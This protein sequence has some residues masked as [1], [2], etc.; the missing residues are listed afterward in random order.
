MGMKN[1]GL[2]LMELMIAIVIVGI[3]AAFAIPSY[4]KAVNKAEERQMMTNLRAIVAAQ[5]IYKAQNGNYWPAH[6]LVAPTANQGIAAINAALKLNILTSGTKY[7]YR[8]LS[9]ANQTYQCYANY[10]PGAL[11]WQLHTN[12]AVSQNTTY[13]SQVC[14]DSAYNPTNP[15]PTLAWCP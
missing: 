11:A 7:N 4:T 8:C 2:T 13:A 5:E 15:C 12:N 14:C 6:V 3:M 10:S 1:R 9:S